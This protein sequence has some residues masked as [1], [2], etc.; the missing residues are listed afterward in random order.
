[1]SA[2]Y[3]V[4]LE[5]PKPGFNTYVNG[6][7]VA[8]A[9]SNIN[10]IARMVGVKTLDEFVSADLT[11][12]FDEEDEDDFHGTVADAH[13]VWF[14]ASEGLDW[15]SKISEYIG[16]NPDDVHDAEHVQEDLAEYQELFKNASEA[17]IRWHLEVDF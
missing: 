2:A 16:N 9:A 12:F 14:D 4:V 17:G 10:R 13:V 3:Y 1:M 7:A 11:E 6:K 8:K 5:D 15:C